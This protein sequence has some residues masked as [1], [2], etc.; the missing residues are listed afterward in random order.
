MKDDHQSPSNSSRTDLLLIYPPW[1]VLGDRAMLQNCLPPLGILSIASHAESLGYKVHV[2]DVHGERADETTVR[3]RL[4]DHQPRF[5]G[6]SVLTNLCIP[7][8]KLARICKTEVP[9]CVVVAGGVHAE[10]MPDRMLRNSAFDC[11]AR[12]DGEEAMI[13]IVKGTPFDAVTGLS[14]RNGFSVRH[15]R[16]RTPEMNL[17]RFPFPAYH[18][19]DF[20]NYFP[21][22]GSYRNL[23]AINMLM[24]RGCPGK[25]VFCNSARTTLRARDPKAVVAQIKHLHENYGIRQI[26]FYDDTFTVLK[27]TCLDF[28]EAMAAEKLDVSWV[29][30]VRGDCFNDEM[31]L[32]MRKA[33]CHQVLM[34]IET[35]SDKIA[36]RIDKPIDRERYKLAVATAHRHGIE[37][38]GSFIIGSME[39]TWET[40]EETLQFAIELDVDLFQLNI[41]TPYPGTVLYR[42]AL[43]KG[44]LLDNDWYDYGQGKVL[45]GQPQLS[46][47]DIYRFERYAFRRF[48]LRPKAAFRMLKRMTSLR[49][50][51]DYFTTALILLLGLQT[52][53]D[54]RDWDCWK[55]LKEEDYFDLP[56]AE[57]ADLRLT[58]QLRQEQASA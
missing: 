38:R 33:G 13:E 51:S 8:H 57:P 35:G 46:N 15:N 42:E 40:M 32:A 34:G 20:T 47:D 6:I 2:V 17:D 29:A 54:H 37:V 48:Y 22:V 7:A 4:R 1:P 19:V 44:W 10:A 16:P 31:A 27:K 53:K 36:A 28:C 56:V 45:V 55:N 9:D 21:P 23:P 43:E 49:H 30:Y 58:Y 26:M 50:L 11:V 5:V 39:E 41:S 52:K 25:C 12:G 24:T 18:L 14:Y 3:Q